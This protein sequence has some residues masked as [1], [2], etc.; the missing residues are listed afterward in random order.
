M[1]KVAIEGK[2]PAMLLVTGDDDDTVSPRNTERMA[3]RLKAVGSPV[4]VKIY[5]G[6]GHVGIILSL[7]PGFRSKTTLREDIVDFVRGVEA[8]G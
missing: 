3:E 8:G 1:G 7:W 4:T 2:R 6:V 5:P